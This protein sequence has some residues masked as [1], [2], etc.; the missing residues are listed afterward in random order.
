MPATIV[1]TFTCVM[2][3]ISL[4]NQFSSSG[5]NTQWGNLSNGLIG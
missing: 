4:G 2:K 1:K 5:S 3:L